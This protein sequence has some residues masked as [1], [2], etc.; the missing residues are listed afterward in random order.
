MKAM[1]PKALEHC[2]SAGEPLNPSVVQQWLKSTGVTICDGWGQTETVLLVGNFEGFPV[3]PGSMGRVSPSFEVSV[4]GPN[5]EELADEEEGELACRVDRG[6]GSRWIFKGYI[7]N[8]QI[9][10]RQ[11]TCNGKTWY[12]TGDRG[13]RD[14]DGY[15]WFVGRDD[16]VITS[17]GYRIG[18]FE[19]ES[20]LKV[21]CYLELIGGSALTAYNCA[22][23]HEA[24]LESAVVA[25][26]DLQRGEIVKA[27][28]VLSDEYRAQNLDHAGR[29]KLVKELQAFTREHT[30]PYKYPRAIEFVETLPKTVSGKIRRVELRNAEYSQKADI[31]KQLKAKL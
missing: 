2:V 24:V 26:P 31:V 30:A 13:R 22:Q 16:D 7:K 28:V 17:S 15:F 14:K 23:A 25:S 4:I 20:A 1:P 9:D 11:K 3:R 5:G 10:K 12:C 27:F 18:P 21:M 29:D 8:G 19:V 6:G